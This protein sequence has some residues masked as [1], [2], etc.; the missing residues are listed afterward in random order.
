MTANIQI[1]VSERREVLKIPNSALRFRP[2]GEDLKAQA[3]SAEGQSAPAP[4]GEAA[5]AQPEE[6]LRQL[7]AALGLNE[8]QQNQARV[9][10]AEVREKLVAMRRQGADPEEIRKEAQA[11]REKT[12]SA[13]AALLS[14]E[15]R[16]KFTALSG[17]PETGPS[18]RGRV[19]I[20][21][22]KGK[23]SPL[24]L[25][26]GITDGTF[27]EVLRGDLTIGRQVVIGVNMPLPKPAARPA[28][29]IG[30]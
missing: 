25:V 21:D 6:R 17:V 5:P 12:R 24:E 8:S 22:P 26:L 4:G 20:L 15:Q 14:A 29:R 19:Y 16:R 30:F 28:A 13:I 2:E 9:I 11:Q 10:L 7:T 27:T 23:P 1:V 18:A 3:P